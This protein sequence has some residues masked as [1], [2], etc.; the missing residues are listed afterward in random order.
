MLALKVIIVF[1][2]F[3]AGILLSAIVHHGRDMRNARLAGVPYNNTMLRRHRTMVYIDTG[4]IV[5]IILLLEVAIRVIGST[6]SLDPV[7]FAVHL[8]CAVTFLGTF[9]MMAFHSTGLHRRERHGALA[10]VSISAFALA[11]ATGSYMLYAL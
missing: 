6:N 3:I 5:G 8:I 4:I 7:L 9:L 1:A 10:K 2:L 11:L